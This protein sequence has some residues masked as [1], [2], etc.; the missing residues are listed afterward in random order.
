MGGKK[1]GRNGSR[2][3]KRHV[4]RHLDESDCVHASRTTCNAYSAKPTT[5]SPGCK[6]H[7]SV[8]HS[9]DHAGHVVAKPQEIGGIAWINS[10]R[11]EDVAEIYAAG[12]DANLHFVRLGSAATGLDAMRGS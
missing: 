2:L 9:L 3:F 11:L 8:A 4:P 12:A 7:T 1:N 10:Q 6:C 5:A